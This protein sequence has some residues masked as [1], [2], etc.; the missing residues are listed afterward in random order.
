MS[1]QSGA[2]DA[3][4]VVLPNDHCRNQQYWQCALGSHKLGLSR[5]QSPPL[6]HVQCS[7]VPPW[8]PW[9]MGRRTSIAGRL[10]RIWAGGQGRS[11]CAQIHYIMNVPCPMGNLLV[12]GAG[13]Y[14][15][16]A[17]VPGTTAIAL[18]LLVCIEATPD[19]VPQWEVVCWTMA[20][21]WLLLSITRALGLRPCRDTLLCV[22]VYL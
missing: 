12:V 11:V 16:C 19:R 17:H 20:G 6:S 18:K 9:R 13:A 8:L 5:S 7:A 22:I 15:L 10:V 1:P 14:T 4:R 21:R 3:D 2:G